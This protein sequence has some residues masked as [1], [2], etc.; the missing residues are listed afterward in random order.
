VLFSISGKVFSTTRF[1]IC[2]IIVCY[3]G[4]EKKNAMECLHHYC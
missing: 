3:C 1:H 2:I 4:K